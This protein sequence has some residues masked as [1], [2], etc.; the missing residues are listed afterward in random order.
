[1]KCARKGCKKDV[2]PEK[3]KYCSDACCKAA[4]Q[5]RMYDQNKSPL[6]AARRL[7]HQKHRVCLGCNKEFMSSGPW[8]R[9]CPTC[10]QKNVGTDKVHA[11][12]LP[13]T[14]TRA[15]GHDIGE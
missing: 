1:M 3:R 5:E 11:L 7:R 8:N 2:P 10:K 15:V 13:R 14:W 6:K 4:N 9:L 12:A